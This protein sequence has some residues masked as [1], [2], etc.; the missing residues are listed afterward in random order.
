MNDQNHEPVF[1]GPMFRESAL[2]AGMVDK[3]K[4]V[5]IAHEC[6][7]FRLECEKL[8]QERDAALCREKLANEN[9]QLAR[10]S[11]QAELDGLRM[12]VNV[13]R[14][15]EKVL[16][17]LLEPVEPVL[18]ESCRS[19]KAENEA[20]KGQVGKLRGALTDILGEAMQPAGCETRC[21]SA[22][23]QIA[24]DALGPEQAAITPYAFLR[25][26]NE[27]QDRQL[28]RLVGVLNSSEACPT[29]LGHVC[30][31]DGRDCRKDSN[32]WF[33]WSRQ[34]AEKDLA[35]G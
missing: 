18:C 34:Q 33:V 5:S 31:Y 3:V 8:I 30:T 1:H 6:D 19:T 15:K 9:S 21:V 14:R 29:P 32:C 13:W 25:R 24:E 10:Q 11:M 7:K 27:I 17:S 22:L 35:N 20:L 16:V 23:E 2:V 28:A 4:S 12:E 26:E